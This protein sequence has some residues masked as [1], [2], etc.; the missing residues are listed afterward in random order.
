MG[1]TNFNS[2]VIDDLTIGSTSISEAEI[3]GL[4][5]GTPG[6]M[7][8]GK[9]LVPTTGGKV[10]ALHIGTL[11]ATTA[12]L[13]ATLT[14]KA[15]SATSA[16]LTG[17]VKALTFTVG[18]SVLTGANFTS[19]TAATSAANFMVGVT[20]ATTTSA[21]TASTLATYATDATLATV[22]NST[23]SALNQVIVDL[24]ARGVIL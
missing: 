7:T 2:L 17:D 6:T 14:G 3:A 8:A 24:K 12:T 22:L 18:T 4:D 9:A 11:Q 16:T 15:I 10:D 5:A 21:P 20:A 13:T 1:T 23:V 19:M